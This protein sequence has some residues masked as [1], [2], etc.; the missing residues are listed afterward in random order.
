MPYIC[1]VIQER[2]ELDIKAEFLVEEKI[3]I[4]KIIINTG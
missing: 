2:M 1:V 4:E 3:N